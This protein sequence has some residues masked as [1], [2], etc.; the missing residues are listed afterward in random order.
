MMVF[1]SAMWRCRK[2][3]PRVLLALVLLA[4]ASAA[5]AG[6]VALTFDDLP[7]AGH[8]ADIATQEAT[9]IALL[10]G[11]R[12][13]HLPATGFVNEI[14]LD[15]NDRDRR[16][17][18][19]SRW[20]DAGMDL[21]NHGYSHLSLTTTPVRAYIDDV[22]RGGAVT[23]ALLAAR[24][25]RERW[26]RH[27]YLE[28][29]T[30][31][32]IRN[33]FE[34]WLAL[35]GYRIAPVTMENSDWQFAP[36]YED[37]LLA[38]NAAE[39][40]RVRATYLDFTERVITWYEAAA[41]Q[42]LGREPRFVFLLHASRLNADSIDALAAILRRRKLRGITLDRAT[43][44]PAYSIADD[45]AGPDGDEWLSRWSLT[46]HRDLPWASLPQVPT[47]IATAAARIDAVPP[48]ATVKPW[49]LDPEP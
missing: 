49:R 41:R 1:A 37:A 8:T 25:R 45:Y 7:Y 34:F 3:V 44:D 22:A 47:A 21:G 15:R 14:Q 2:S 19:L 39:A 29:G 12:R 31:A 32:D 42:L 36:P 23:G 13:H 4:G 17:A 30:T 11:L 16:I 26:F 33:D 28:T 27:P 5:S 46:L 20:L 10:A 43:A 18:L 9:T 35:H 24:G 40:A 6:E 48:P 38:G